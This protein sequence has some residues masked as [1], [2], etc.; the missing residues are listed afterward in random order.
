M[1]QLSNEFQVSMNYGNPQERVPEAESIT[2][3][4]FATT[5]ILVTES[6]KKLNFDSAKNG[7]SLFYSPRMILHQRNLDYA[8]HCQYTFGTTYVQEAHEEPVFH[9][10]EEPVNETENEEAMLEVNPSTEDDTV[11]N[12]RTT[13]SGRVSRPPSKQLWSNIICMLK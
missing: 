2:F 12:A 9:E 6:A 4:K 10:K 5:K 1:E 8:R 11:P 3:Q 7:I 13:R